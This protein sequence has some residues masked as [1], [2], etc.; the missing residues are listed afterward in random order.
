M[1]TENQETRVLD[2]RAKN[3]IK[4]SYDAGIKILEIEKTLQSK[5][6]K[7]YNAAITGIAKDMGCKQRR[8][9]R[10]K[11]VANLIDEAGKQK[12]IEMYSNGV[13]NIKIA[14][15]LNKMGYTTA[16]AKKIDRVWVFKKAA[17][18]GCKMKRNLKREKKPVV[19][20][21]YAVPM[22]Q[23][24]DWSKDCMEILNSNLSQSL[25]SEFI[26]AKL[27]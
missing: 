22:G 27:K 4:R 7:I 23:T 8:P 1:L 15:A 2:D 12:L 21:G 19:E 16:Q 9:R 6:Y 11:G 18:L 14:K 17:E 26:K 24:D 25:K 3:Y 13:A 10:A 5:G 20:N